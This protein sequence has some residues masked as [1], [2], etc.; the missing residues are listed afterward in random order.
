M[1]HPKTMTSATIPTNAT[2]PTVIVGPDGVHTYPGFGRFATDCPCGAAGFP[3]TRWGTIDWCPT[4][5]L[6]LHYANAAPESRP[7]NNFLTVFSYSLIAFLALR[8]ILRTSTAALIGLCLIIGGLMYDIGLGFPGV[9]AASTTAGTTTSSTAVIASELNTSSATAAS[10]FNSWQCGPLDQWCTGQDQSHA[11]PKLALPG[12]WLVMLVVLAC[13]LGMAVG[14]LRDATMASPVDSPSA[15]IAAAPR[16]EPSLTAVHRAPAGRFFPKKVEV[17]RSQPAV[18]HKEGQSIT[19]VRCEKPG[20]IKLAILVTFIVLCLMLVPMAL[21][22]PTQAST[23]VNALTLSSPSP[24]STALNATGT[25]SQTFDSQGEKIVFFAPDSHSSRISMHSL[26]IMIPLLVMLYFVLPTLASGVQTSMP[27]TS[28]TMSSPTPMPTV[29]NATAA[30]QTAESQEKDRPQTW[31]WN[32]HSG[33]SEHS[34]MRSWLM[35]VPLFLMG[36]FLLPAL[37]AGAKEKDKKPVDTVI[38]AREASPQ[39]LPPI[40]VTYYSTTTVWLPVVTVTAPPVANS[41]QT[42]PISEAGITWQTAQPAI[43]TVCTEK[44]PAVCPI[45]LG[46]KA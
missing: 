3:C 8:S 42:A 44:D 24:S 20:P 36:F 35:T 27:A 9:N 5:S 12:F 1:S 21:A 6:G 25:Y 18:K 14:Q 11:V 30:N 23:P 33:S 31:F 29:F 45:V 22:E 39:D 4:N 37:A 10:R 32:P 13:W 40:W 19:D 46:R 43:G 38:L 17:K 34:S 16:E 26:L 15:R 41:A 7:W 2:L 28:L